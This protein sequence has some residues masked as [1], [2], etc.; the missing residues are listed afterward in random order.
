MRTAALQWIHEDALGL[1]G[2]IWKR[3]AGLRP[4]PMS[5]GN[6]AASQWIFEKIA[7]HD[8]QVFSPPGFFIRR[9]TL[10]MRSVGPGGGPLRDEGVRLRAGACSGSRRWM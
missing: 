2:K 9:R 1:N 8:P 7:A 3:A 5:F 6:N 4:R 10:L